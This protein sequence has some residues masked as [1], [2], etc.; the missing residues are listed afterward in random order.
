MIAI[1]AHSL[2]QTYVELKPEDLD[3]WRALK[4]TDKE[5]AK[6]KAQSKGETLSSPRAD[7]EADRDF[8][9]IIYFNEPKAEDAEVHIAANK[10]E[11]AL[12]THYEGV[13]TSM[14]AA[15]VPL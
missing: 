3:D 5:H 2:C 10:Q 6:E 15:K 12:G 9:L 14:F 7:E 1:R 11:Q 4:D 8:S 13:L